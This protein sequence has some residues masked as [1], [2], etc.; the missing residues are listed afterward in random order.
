[1][2]VEFKSISRILFIIF[3]FVFYDLYSQ[4]SEINHKIINMYIFSLIMYFVF[5]SFSGLTAQRLSLYGKFFDIIL[6][7]NIF[8][9]FKNFKIK[10]VYL[11]FLIVF[12]GMYL[13]KDL[14]AMRNSANLMNNSTIVPYTNIFNYDKYLFDTKYVD[15]L[16]ND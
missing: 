11:V 8:Y 4:K 13:T 1:V 16:N 14:Y 3:A 10:A 9:L 7:T 12:C 2:I 5:I 6:F 15:L